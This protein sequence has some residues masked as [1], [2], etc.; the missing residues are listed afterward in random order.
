MLYKRI[1]IAKIVDERGAQ[2]L[3]LRHPVTA[4]ARAL[5]TI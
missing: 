2:A 1:S 4:R 3:T 5:T